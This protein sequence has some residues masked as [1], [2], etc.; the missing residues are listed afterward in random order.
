[1]KFRKIIATVLLTVLLS[2]VSPF[3]AAAEAKGK[4]SARHHHRNA[5]TRGWYYTN[6]SG[7]RVHS[8][9]RAS[10]V[11][12]GATAECNDGTFSFSQNHRGTC[13]HHGGVKRWFR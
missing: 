10:R 13:S 3:A 4:H 6:A 8:P 5:V 9:V 7:V 12:D 2:S 1:M 11:P